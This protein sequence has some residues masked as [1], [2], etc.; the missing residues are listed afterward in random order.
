MFKSFKGWPSK[1]ASIDSN[2]VRR[3]A[4]DLANDGKGEILV[5]MK[6]PPASAT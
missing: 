5:F 4:G 3:Y 6:S 1:F 2:R